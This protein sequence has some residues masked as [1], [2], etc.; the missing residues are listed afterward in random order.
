MFNRSRK[1]HAVPREGDTVVTLRCE[2][3]RSLEERMELL[4]FAF[5]KL[6]QGAVL[7][8]VIKWDLRNGEIKFIVGEGPA[9]P[10]P[11]GKMV[12]ILDDWPAKGIQAEE[13]PMKKGK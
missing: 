12:T 5:A 11:R 8:Q 10:S 13:T 1:E 4:S 6:V 7:R 3:D 2:K 9:L